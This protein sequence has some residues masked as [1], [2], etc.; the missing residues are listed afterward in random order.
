MTSERLAALKKTIQ[1][2]LVEWK[3]THGDEPCAMLEANWAL[4]QEVERMTAF[5]MNAIANDACQ[6]LPDG[7]SIAIDLYKDAACLGLYD[8]GGD[9]VAVSDY[10]P[11]EDTL[12]EGVRLAVAHAER[13]AAEGGAM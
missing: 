12:D 7:Y 2:A 4:V 11:A 8:P 5:T 9:E 13:I 10:D 1:H 3:L 6:R